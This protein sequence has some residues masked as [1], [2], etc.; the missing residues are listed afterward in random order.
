MTFEGHSYEQYV[1]N[2]IN[3][4]IPKLENSAVPAQPN[5]S[6]AFGYKEFS[7]KKY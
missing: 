6:S 2:E 7:S 5:N 3:Q 1:V 4:L